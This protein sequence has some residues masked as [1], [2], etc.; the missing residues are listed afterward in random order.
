MSSHVEKRWVWASK[1]RSS[2]FRRL[3]W[4]AG[5][6]AFLSFGISNAYAMDFSQTHV[7]PFGGS[8]DPHPFLLMRG[9]IVPGDYDR[10]ILYANKMAWIWR[11]SA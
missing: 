3:L 7:N 8:V 6:L 4:V 9:E 1:G 10:L 5:L 2:T 11:H